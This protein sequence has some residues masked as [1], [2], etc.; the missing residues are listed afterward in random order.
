[1]VTFFF[2]YS[3]CNRFQESIRLFYP[4]IIVAC[5]TIFG[6]VYVNT[7][8]F[9]LPVKETTYIN[10]RSS[11]SVLFVGIDSM[12]KLNL[13]RTMPKVYNYLEKKYLT[14]KGYN[15]IG[16]NTFP[17]LMA[18]LTGETWEALNEICNEN[19]KANYCN[20]IWD[21]FKK[22]GYI[23]AYAEDD[24][25]IS[26]FNYLRAGFLEPPTDYYYHPYIVASEHISEKR[27]S[28]MRYCSGPETSGERILNAATD[29]SITHKQ[30]PFFGL[31]WMNSFSHDDVN[32]PS[33]M[34]N[35]VYNFLTNENFISSLNNT[36]FVFFSDHGY[37]FGDI[38]NTETG[39]FEERLPFM[40]ILVPEILKNMY[41]E[42]YS[43]LLQ[44][45]NRLTSPFDIYSTLQEILKMG[46]K[47]HVVTNNL[48]CPNCISL[49]RP[50]HENRTC[51][52]AG[53][54]NHWCTCIGNKHISTN[55]EFLK[56]VANFITETINKLIYSY[57]D[58]KLCVEYKLAEIRSAKMSDFYSRSNN[59]TY[60][61]VM[62]VITTAP[63][64]KFEATVEVMNWKLEDFKISGTISRLSRYSEKSVCV[65]EAVLKKYCYCK[66]FKT[67]IFF[68]YFCNIVG[69]C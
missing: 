63:E 41:P 3:K 16:D 6:K 57:S 50:I 30:V 5:S 8:A 45:T 24:C 1:M 38:R 22:C 12:S 66:N 21:D 31:F 49:F 68:R 28:G 7:H 26:T 25:R 48:G 54:V 47:S 40:Y 2:R 52:N 46:N 51:A 32:L 10:Q 18:I 58:G 36:L 17:N 11:L 15:K 53:I 44:N 59:E 55:Q 43:N 19:T 20:I 69:I 29:F 42:A 37:R 60:Q 13:A 39:W 14:L 9:T 4:F 23:T 27:I 34:E 61:Y 56:P 65:H 62:M 33:A 35:S 67:N 64:D